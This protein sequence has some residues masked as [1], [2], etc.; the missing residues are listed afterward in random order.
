MSDRRQRIHE[1]VLALIQR[2]EGLELLEGDGQGLNQAT[3]RDAASWLER[4]RRLVQRYQALVRTAITL[5]ALIDQEVA[6]Q[7]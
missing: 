5:D 6:G 4:N 2:Q 3:G 7:L 1:L